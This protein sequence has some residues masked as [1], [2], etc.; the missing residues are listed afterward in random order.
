MVGLLGCKREEGVGRYTTIV[1]SVVTPD[2]FKTRH[3]VGRLDTRRIKLAELINIIQ[4]ISDIALKRRNFIV[5][6]L[7]IA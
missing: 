7:Q 5:G 2:V 3:L 6:Q 1:D 4:N